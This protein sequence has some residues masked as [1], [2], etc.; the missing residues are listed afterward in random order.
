M[1]KFRY[2]YY[3]TYIELEDVS[4]LQHTYGMTKDESAKFVCYGGYDKDNKKKHKVFPGNYYRTISTN[5]FDAPIITDFAK[6]IAANGAKGYQTREE[7]L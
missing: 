5:T 1:T 4:I 7:G 3:E 6:F 2:G